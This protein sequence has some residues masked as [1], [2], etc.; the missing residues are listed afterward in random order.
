M[1]LVKGLIGRSTTLLLLLACIHGSKTFAKNKQ[2]NNAFYCSVHIID[3][4]YNRKISQHFNLFFHQFSMLLILE[5]AKNR[6]RINDA[7]EKLSKLIQ[8][9]T[10]SRGQIEESREVVD[11]VRG[12]IDSIK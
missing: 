1:G 6:T 8:K 3:H 2:G 11:N 10:E 12:N 4:V 5:I 9:I 7:N